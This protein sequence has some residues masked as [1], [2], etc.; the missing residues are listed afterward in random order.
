MSENG[1]NGVEHQKL[2][3]I[4]LSYNRATD[5]LDVGGHANS[6]DLMLD[7]LARATRAIEKQKRTQDALELQAQLQRQAEDARIA[8][9]LRKGS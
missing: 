9:A 5:H 4:V 1:E 6:L 3:T 7:M 8:A 2:D